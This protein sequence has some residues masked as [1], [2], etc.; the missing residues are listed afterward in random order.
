[1]FH[2]DFPEAYQG[3]HSF[4]SNYESATTYSGTLF[5]GL[6]LFNG[7]EIYFDPEVTAGSGLSGTLGL[8]DPPN[9]ESKSVGSTEPTPNV[10][11][12]FLRQVFG[13]G[14]GQEPIADGPNSIAGK[15]DINRLTITVGKL[16]VSDIFDNNTYAHDSRSQF[17]NWSLADNAAWDSAADALGYTDGLALEANTSAATLRYGIFRPPAVANHGQLDTHYDR[18]FDQVLEFEQRYTLLGRNGVL[19]PMFFFD[20][21]HMGDYRDAIIS[22]PQNPD[23]TLSRSYSHPKYGFGLNTEQAITDDLGFFTR[24]GW[25]NGQSEAWSYTEADRSVSVGLSVKGSSWQRPNDVIGLAGV[26]SG[27]SKDHRDY[28]AAGGLGFE[29]G[30]G[31]LR[32]SPEEV[33]EC[34]YS[35]VMTRNLFLSADYQFIDHPG[36]NADRG[37]VSIGGVRVHF[38]F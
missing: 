26:M 19:R 34:Y 29:L 1:M 14:G 6:R 30:D 15:Q 8:G 7:T 37:P 35:L 21:A 3:P 24:L 32:Y 2:G 20:E 17:Y 16:A 4:S 31:R 13:F 28:L 10:A 9:G 27:L 22:Q 25:S 33:I 38:E 5:M 36:Y 11:R 18:A 23:V 12:L